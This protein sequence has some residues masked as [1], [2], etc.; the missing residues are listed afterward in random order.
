M[1]IVIIHLCK[2]SFVATAEDMENSKLV[3]Q[4]QKK[5]RQKKNMN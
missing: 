2:M 1:P 3:L 5:K 4:I